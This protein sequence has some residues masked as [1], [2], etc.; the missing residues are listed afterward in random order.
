MF[1]NF[2]D[3][4]YESKTPFSALSGAAAVCTSAS[5]PAPINFKRKRPQNRF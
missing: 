2:S 5:C 1:K 4:K 3:V